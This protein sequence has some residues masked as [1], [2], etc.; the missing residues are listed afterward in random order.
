MHREALVFA[1]RTLAGLHL[2]PIRALEIGARD[3]NGSVRVIVDR[4][5]PESYVGIDIAPG[6]GVD[7]LGDG[8]DYQPLARPNLII[9]TEVLEHT[10][11]ARDVVRQIGRVL[12][13]GGFALITCATDPRVPHSAVDGNAVREG[14]YYG[15]VG[16]QDLTEWMVLA[17]LDALTFEVHDDR[18]DL[19][20]YAQK[21]EA[22][23]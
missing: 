19:Y 8:S 10:P 3:F 18:G 14:E 16:P 5:Q 17:G 13:P 2:R 22:D 4:L 20:T 11:H 12:E 15:N 21:P 6:P 7:A 23:G 9:C 1:A